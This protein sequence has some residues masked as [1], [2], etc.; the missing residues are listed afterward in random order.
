MLEKGSQ[1]Y[2]ALGIL[3]ANR[4]DLSVSR[5]L[6]TWQNAGFFLSWL[7]LAESPVCGSQTARYQNRESLALLFEESAR[8]GRL[9]CMPCS[10]LL[11]FLHSP[12]TVFTAT[13]FLCNK[14][15]PSQLQH[16]STNDQCCTLLHRS[17]AKPSW[18]S[19][20]FAVIIFVRYC[21]RF[22]LPRLYCD[23]RRLLGFVDQLTWW[24]HFTPGSHG[25]GFLLPFFSAAAWPL[26]PAAFVLISGLYWAW[27]LPLSN[28]TESC[29]SHSL[30]RFCLY[31]RGDHSSLPGKSSMKNHDAWVRVFPMYD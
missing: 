27:K 11:A 4:S 8:G 6:T 18:T 17:T 15:Y 7:F 5:P 21:S 2:V 10:S 22:C 28:L 24:W 26:G 30:G 9:C 14:T 31:L 20:N 25:F 16:Q 29:F 12:N 23:V 19:P 1:L 13:P 3:K